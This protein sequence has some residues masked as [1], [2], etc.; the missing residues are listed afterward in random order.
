MDW[1]TE[2]T[3]ALA[4]SRIAIVCVTA[5]NRNSPWLLFESGTIAHAFGHNRVIPYLFNVEPV[6]LTGPLAHF[7]YVRSDKNGTF[8]LFRS[9][10]D[11]APEEIRFGNEKLEHVF[12]VWWPEIE[13]ALGQIPKT[14]QATRATERDLLE[15]ILEILRPRQREA[16]IDEL[17][18][19]AWRAEDFANLTQNQLEDFFQRILWPE[20]K[21]RGQRNWQDVFAHDPIK[22]ARLNAIEL[23]E[24][25]ADTFG[26]REQWDRWFAKTRPN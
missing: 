13:K 21:E 3:T 11:L 7:Q 24:T 25:A 6:D 1:W 22:N 2:L 16:A 12:E 4:T 19:R 5:D 8:E 9:I 14:Q 23:A 17:R 20:A 15:Q 10:N 26:I 18:E